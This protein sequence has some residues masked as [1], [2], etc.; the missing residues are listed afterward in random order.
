M[1]TESYIDPPKITNGCRFSVVCDQVLSHEHSKIRLQA[2]QC[3]RIIL[4]AEEDRI[5]SGLARRQ[6]NEKLEAQEE[7]CVA[8]FQTA[9]VTCA[10]PPLNRSCQPLLLR[11]PAPQFRDELIS[12]E[13]LTGGYALGNTVPN[14][15]SSNGGDG[16]KGASIVK[17]QVQGDQD[18]E[19]S[20]VGGVLQ[21]HLNAVLGLLFDQVSELRSATILLLGVM[22]RQGLVNPL[23]VLPHVIALLGD[24]VKDI[25]AEALRLLVVEDE[26]H[27]DFLK[28]RMLEGL[29]T[30]Y[31]FQSKT[32][33]RHAPLVRSDGESF[34]GNALSIFSGV[35]AACIRT[36]RVKRNTMLRV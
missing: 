26:K 18:G 10:H 34:G 36:N 23:E 25:R 27:P 7:R 17:R 3:W 13:E 31:E 21:M 16:G 4:E 32:F 9:L 35:Y 2:L 11:S 28:T 33:G 12:E 24:Q 30:T 5:E 22:L 14:G 19:S 1:K 29:C 6:L 15:S 20:V 8:S